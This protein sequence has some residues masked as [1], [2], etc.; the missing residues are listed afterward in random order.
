ME[1]RSIIWKSDFR[2]QTEHRIEVKTSENMDEF[3][4]YVHTS[5]LTAIL[6]QKTVSHTTHIHSICS[7]SGCTGKKELWLMLWIPDVLC[8]IW[9]VQCWDHN[10]GLTLTGVLCRIALVKIARQLF[11]AI[12]AAGGRESVG[13]VL[14]L[15]HGGRVSC[16]LS[17]L[18]WSNLVS[19]WCS[20]LE[21]YP[22]VV[23][24][25]HGKD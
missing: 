13:R 11:V 5:S 7:I 12:D 24:W 6:P 3:H 15:A 21:S 25:Y 18:N 10:G 22:T 23:I 1:R 17:S 8:D 2:E 19:K 4:V 14:L 9:S 20:V 16:A